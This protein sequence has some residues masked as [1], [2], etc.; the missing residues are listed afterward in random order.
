ML[1][2]DFQKLPCQRRVKLRDWSLITGSGATE[3]RGGGGRKSFSILKEGG[4]GAKK[5]STL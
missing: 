4:G 5:V 3:R 2:V 1:H